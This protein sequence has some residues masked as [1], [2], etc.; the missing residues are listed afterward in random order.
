MPN[1]FLCFVWLAVAGIIVI[2]ISDAVQDSKNSANSA[3]NIINSSGT[4]EDGRTIT[5]DPEY[6]ED[7]TG[8]TES[9]GDEDL[10]I[11]LDDTL[12]IVPSLYVW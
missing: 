5:V 6:L 2:F 8:D 3:N 4:T 10:T 7:L 12:C 1:V 11:S 9:S